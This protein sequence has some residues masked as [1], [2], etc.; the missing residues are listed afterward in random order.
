MPPNVTSDVQSRAAHSIA[1]TFGLGEILPA[2]GTTAGSLP[3]AIVWWTLAAILGVSGH[4][5]AI[6]GL[7]VMAAII[8]GI[9]ASG[10]EALR[11]GAEDPGPVVIDEVAGQWL[12]YLTA[13][14]FTAL[15]GGGLSLLLFTAGGFFGFRLFDV[16]KPWP[17]SRLER[18]PGGVGIVAD[19]LA[20]GALAGVVLAIGWRFFVG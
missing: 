8:V 19:D 10:V 16:W 2:P 9:W 18:L 1:T 7:L 20:A 4:L 11:R 6:T 17:I 15:T 12:C 5:L 13:L 3:A 14:P